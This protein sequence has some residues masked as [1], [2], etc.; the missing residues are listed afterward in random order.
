MPGELDFIEKLL[1]EPK[2]EKEHL[3]SVADLHIDDLLRYAASKGASD[4]HFSAGLPPMLRIDGKLVPSS[5]HEVMTA[6]D[7]Q[8]LIY[9]VMTN[10]QIQWFEKVKELDCSY[11]VKDVGRFRVNVYKQR[12]A[13]GVAMRAIPSQIPTFEQ[14]R[15]PPILREITKRSSGLILVTGPTGSGKSTTLA[16]MINSI[17]EERNCHIVTIEDPIEYL[18]KHKQ[19]MVNQRELGSDTDSFENALRA[20]LREDPDV[21]LVGEMRDLETITAAL[22][23]AETG[24]LVLA[25]LHT[26]SAP[27]TIERIIDVFPAHQ[28]EQ[29]RVQLSNSL[30]AVVAQ[31]LLPMLGGGRIVAIELM[32]AV[33]A[34]R[35]LIREAKAYQ[36]YSVIETN[37]QLGMKTMDKALAELYRMGM[38]SYEE[39]AARAMDRDNFRKF[40]K[41]T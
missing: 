32:V 20:V 3:I 36:I 10:E 14:L 1:A 6:R 39:A 35:N 8:R 12:G 34:I 22:T 15:L 18:H 27:Q 29:I 31:Q 41:G 19:S 28:Q 5:E 16:C 24:H 25:T 26:R 40:V 7:I 38:V 2:S 4:L 13:V 37:A 30:E 23:L 33:P 17:N 9:D 11:G 21:I